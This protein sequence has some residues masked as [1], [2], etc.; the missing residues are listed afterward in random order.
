MDIN[1]LILNP[2]KIVVAKWTVKKYWEETPPEIFVG[3][4]I[5]RQN[6]DVFAI[7][8]M[9]SANL[10]AANIGK[11]WE[12]RLLTTEPAKWVEVPDERADG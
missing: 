7:G 1:D 10:L 3:Y 4:G 2:G 11:N 8:G 6:G 5:I 12:A 9:S